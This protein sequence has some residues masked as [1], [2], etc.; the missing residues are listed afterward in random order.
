MVIHCIDVCMAVHKL[1]HHTLHCQSGCE[2]EWCGAII[3]TSIKIR[4]TVPDEN[5]E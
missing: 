1:L 5:L 2:D 4:G 3:H